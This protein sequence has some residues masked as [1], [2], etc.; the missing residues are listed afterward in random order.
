MRRKRSRPE[1][2]HP[3]VGSGLVTSSEMDVP[4]RALR[5]STLVSSAALGRS[6]ATA[7]AAILTAVVEAS[8][9][10]P[11]VSLSAVQKEK[12]RSR[13]E[14]ERE[15]SGDE[16]EDHSYEHESSTVVEDPLD[17]VAS[18]E[19]TGDLLFSPPRLS[20]EDALHTHPPVAE[21]G[22]HAYSTS[23]FSPPTVL[24]LDECLEGIQQQDEPPTILGTTVSKPFSQ[25]VCDAEEESEEEEGV[26]LGESAPVLFCDAASLTAASQKCENGEGRADSSTVEE[27]SNR[28]P[29]MSSFLAKPLS[30]S[31]LLPLEE[32]EE[33][34]DSA[35]DTLVESIS[36]ENNNI[37]ISSRGSFLNANPVPFTP[38][39][40][41]VEESHVR[42]SQ[43]VEEEE[44]EEEGMLAKP[45][46]QEGLLFLDSS[47]TSPAPDSPPAAAPLQNSNSINPHSLSTPLGQGGGGGKT[48]TNT[49][50]PLIHAL[51]APPPTTAS[52]FSQSVA[53]EEDINTPRHQLLASKAMSSLKSSLSFL[54]PHPKSFRVFSAQ[55]A[56]NNPC[57]D[58]AFSGRGEDLA[59]GGDFYLFIIADG[60][61]GK[62]V[63]SLAASRL[64]GIILDIFSNHPASTT[65]ETVE[66]LKSA[67]AR[68]DSLWLTLNKAD[69]D[70]GASCKG[71]PSAA[72]VGVAVESQP[73]KSKPGAFQPWEVASVSRS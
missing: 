14:D 20:T 38:R 47:F 34:G 28:P 16:E 24:L 1:D 57:E 6:P 73:R 61:G 63:S 48:T 43:K 33:A 35:D 55:H 18:E 60:H 72:G 65:S 69:L 40:G 2:E 21:A 50:H 62:E 17:R 51:G 42:E 67:Y 15:L 12:R 58:F 54:P 5:L 9:V 10:S 32:E 7:E 3:P 44:E 59:W 29:T 49:T 31:D 71:V 45:F 70:A 30:Q 36:E 64:P 4:K 37:I 53:L 25:M 11:L 13:I 46:S 68:L 26:L 19:G 22:Y 41:E 27:P 66:A 56:A 52:N 23:P 8:E 39:G